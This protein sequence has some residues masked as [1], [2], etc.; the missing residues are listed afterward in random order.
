VQ[1]PG[2]P[3]DWTSP[4]FEPT[5]RDGRLYARGATDDKGN[6]LQ[7]LHVACAMARAG[8]L[9]VHVRVLIEGAEEIGPDDVGEWVRADAR[10]ADAVIVFD[11]RMF[12]ADTPALTLA[13]RGMVFAHVEV[14]TGTQPAHSGMYG[15]AALNAFHALHKALAAVLPGPDGKLPEPL[16]AGVNPPSELEIADWAKLPAGEGELVGARPSDPAATTEFYVRTTAEPSLDVHRVEGGQARTIVV[17]VA[18]ADLSVRIVGGQRSEEIARN[19]EQLLRDALPDGAELTF[20]ADRAEGSAFDPE[21]S[22]LVAARHALERAVGSEPALVRTG[23]TLPV[24]AAFAERGIPAIV[25]GFS[26]PDDALHAPNE[27]Y[28]LVALSRARRPRGRSTRS[29]PHS[30][31]RTRGSAR[32][33]AGASSQRPAR[34]RVARERAFPARGRARRRPRRRGAEGAGGRAGR[35]LGRDRVRGARPQGARLRPDPVAAVADRAG[36]RQRTVFLLRALDA[37]MGGGLVTAVLMAAG[38][39]GWHRAA[40][41]DLVDVARRRAERVDVS[42]VSDAQLDNAIALA[43]LLGVHHDR[44]RARAGDRRAGGGDPRRQAADRRRRAGQ[45]APDPGARRRGCAR[46]RGLCDVRGRGAEVNAGMTY[47]GELEGRMR[48]IVETLTGRDA[49]WIIPALEQMLYAGPYRQNPRGAL[50]LLMAGLTDAAPR[51]HVV[52]IAD[53]GA[54]ERLVRAQPVIELVQLVKRRRKSDQLGRPLVQQHLRQQLLEIGAARWVT[55]ASALRLRRAR[56]SGRAA[57]DG[58]RAV[59]SAS[60]TS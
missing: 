28:R 18:S 37:Q 38:R 51:M 16:R 41:P 48:H 32:V 47:V 54:Y 1:D 59:P 55:E 24:L 45:R 19:L 22:A 44:R 49:I 20:S 29:S 26:L 5:V 12:D 30:D 14:R 3:E 13:T 43:R 31:E 40:L 50:D 21:H 52:G 6:F 36:P 4:P 56:C 8:E 17:P 7:L 60:L 27:S 42:G 23:G 46:A 58:R 11:S 33:P 53:P 35:D 39:S 10:G 9:P 25:S 57:A 2:A 34:R 15:G